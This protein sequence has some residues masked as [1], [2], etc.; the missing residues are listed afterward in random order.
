MSSC[1]GLAYSL[2]SVKAA[3]NEFSQMNQHTAVS[4]QYMP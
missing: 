4:I 1:K 3:I 2:Q